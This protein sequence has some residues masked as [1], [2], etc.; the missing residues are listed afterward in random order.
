MRPLAV[1]MHTFN[2]GAQEGAF[3]WS[4]PA[5][6]TER[7]LGQPGLQRNP[8]SNTHTHTHSHI[9]SKKPQ[10]FNK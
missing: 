8:V 10:T 1:V 2:P 5:W 3:L 4:R 9:T 6:S 7:V